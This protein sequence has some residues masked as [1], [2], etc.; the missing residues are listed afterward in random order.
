MYLPEEFQLRPARDTDSKAAMELIKQSYHEYAGQGVVFDEEEHSDLNALASNFAL[1]KG[2]AFVI[3]DNTPPNR[4]VGICGFTPLSPEIIELKKL[5]VN[6]DSR[7]YGLGQYLVCY[8]ID[9]AKNLE[10]RELV[11]WTDIRFTKAHSLYEKLG[12]TKAPT[13]RKLVDKSRSEEFAYRLALQ[14]Q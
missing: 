9:L 12:F 3:T 6:P 8:A 5:Y 13:T 10:A 14:S 2:E 4:L 1:N 7:G 11:L